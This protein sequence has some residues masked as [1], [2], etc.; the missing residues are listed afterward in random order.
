[1]RKIST[2]LVILLL[3]YSGVAQ[4]A[5]TQGKRSLIVKT[6]YIKEFQQVVFESFS[7]KPKDY[8]LKRLPK[9]LSKYG[10][11]NVEITSLGS[12]KGSQEPS[13]ISRMNVAIA[14]AQVGATLSNV[15]N[16]A[17]TKVDKTLFQVNF[18]SDQGEFKVRLNVFVN[19]KY[20]IKDTSK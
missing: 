9:K 3:S 7:K 17:T 14:K 5:P 13:L 15:Y 10:F 2:I 4:I 12:V 1:M 16:T 20:I 6:K 8:H 19:P 18:T 11:T